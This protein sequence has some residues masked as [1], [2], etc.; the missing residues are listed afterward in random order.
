MNPATHDPAQPDLIGF[1]AME[2]ENAA[3]LSREDVQKALRSNNGRPVRLNLSVNGVRWRAVRGDWSL[4][5]TR[6]KGYPVVWW[7]IFQAD[8]P[9][10]GFFV[11]VSSAT[12]A[13]W[14]RQWFRNAIHAKTQQWAQK[15]TNQEELA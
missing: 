8:D 11:T 12:C 15:A 10:R 4:K 13:D 1:T 14:L 6:D 7:H 3:F 2:A 9:E 5:G